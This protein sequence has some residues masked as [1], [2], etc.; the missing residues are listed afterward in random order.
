MPAR[1]PNPYDFV[2]ATVVQAPSFGNIADLNAE[3]VNLNG[4]P[5]FA[6]PGFA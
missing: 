6:R 5:R 3:P 4:T 2:R 1:L